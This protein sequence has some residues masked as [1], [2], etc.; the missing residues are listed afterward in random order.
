MIDNWFGGS[1][2]QDTPI[3]GRS[4]RLP[5]LPLPLH[6]AFYRRNNLVPAFSSLKLHPVLNMGLRAKWTKLASTARLQRSSQSLS[7]VGSQVLIFGGELLPRQPVDNKIDSI[8]LGEPQ[9][10]IP[11]SLCPRQSLTI[12]RGRNLRWAKRSTLSSGR[13]CQCRRE[14]GNVPLLWPRRRFNGTH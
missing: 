5:H 9:N 12:I 11:P 1:R 3:R 10:G 2:F 13:H 14:W 7:V 4:H 6:P 8:P